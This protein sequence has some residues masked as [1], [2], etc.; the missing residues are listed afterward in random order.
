MTFEVGELVKYIDAEEPEWLA[1][2][3]GTGKSWNNDDCPIIYVHWITGTL[4]DS[5]YEK[6]SWYPTHIFKKVSNE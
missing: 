2:V 5:E 1:V 3:L 6:T 4:V